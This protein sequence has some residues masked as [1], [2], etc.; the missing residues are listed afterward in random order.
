MSMF[1][2]FILVFPRF[3]ACGHYL[4][5]AGKCLGAVHVPFFII[6]IISQEMATRKSMPVKT[7]EKCSPGLAPHSLSFYNHS[8]ED[9]RDNGFCT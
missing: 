7:R 5:A 1:M 4:C 8:E 2:V 9:I 3:L 6:I